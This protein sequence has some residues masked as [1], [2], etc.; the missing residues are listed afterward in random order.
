[1]KIV[2]YLLFISAVV[3]LISST[4]PNPHA[5]NI[6][7]GVWG[8]IFWLAGIIVAYFDRERKIPERVK[9]LKRFVTAMRDELY[10]PDF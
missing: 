7:L 10:S 5:L 9:G 6:V 8:A 1:M 2:K 4:L 3:L